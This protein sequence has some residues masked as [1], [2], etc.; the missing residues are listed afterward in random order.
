MAVCLH[1]NSRANKTLGCMP[2]NDAGNRCA[3]CTVGYL[4]RLVHSPYLQPLPLNSPALDVPPN[5]FT[6]CHCCG[7]VARCGYAWSIVRADPLRRGPL[8]CLITICCNHLKIYTYHLRLDTRLN[9]PSPPPKAS[10]ST[11]LNPG[12]RLA[13]LLLRGGGSCS[14]ITSTKSSCGGGALLVVVVSSTIMVSFL[15]LEALR[16]GGGVGSRRTS[17][18]TTSLSDTLD[19]TCLLLRGGDLRG[20]DRGLRDG[21]R[22][23]RRM[24]SSSTTEDRPCGPPPRPK[25][26]MMSQRTRRKA[27]T[28]PKTMPTTVPGVGPEPSP[29]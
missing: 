19:A 25:H 5:R 17:S 3:I 10:G 14:S 22:E 28:E 20:E 4:E 1:F 29:V 24:I 12:T 8:R 13:L 23:R 7:C 6:S 9:F 18:I 27:A 15:R 26:V 16:G 21:D 2:L 11:C